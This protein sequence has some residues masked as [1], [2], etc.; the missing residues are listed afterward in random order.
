MKINFKEY[1]IAISILIIC[2]SC[3]KD[4]APIADRG[5]AIYKEYCQ[6]CHGDNGA[7]VAGLNA[8]RGRAIWKAPAHE[9]IRTLVYGASGRNAPNDSGRTMAMPPVPY[10][11]DDISKVANY[12]MKSI[13]G[14]NERITPE[15][16]TAVR[17]NR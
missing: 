6:R 7:G 14:S 8:I 5:Q 17:A 15:D 11:D 1:V 2:I 13:G 3:S 12:V 16:V 10:S 4:E 9:I